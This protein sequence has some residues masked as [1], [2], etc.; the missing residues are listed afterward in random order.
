ML[1]ETRSGELGLSGE[2]EAGDPAWASE[3]IQGPGALA[4]SSRMAPEDI[5]CAG[6]NGLVKSAF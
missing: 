1:G 5:W 2:R 4:Q 6:G 3:L